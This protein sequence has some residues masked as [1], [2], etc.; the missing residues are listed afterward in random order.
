ME[1]FDPRFHRAYE[2]RQ[3]ADVHKCGRKTGA[4]AGDDEPE[5]SSVRQHVIR[6]VVEQKRVFFSH[7]VFERE[8]QGS[9]DLTIG[10]LLFGSRPEDNLIADTIRG[11]AHGGHGACSVPLKLIEYE[12][13]SQVPAISE[14]VLANLKS[15]DGEQYTLFLPTNEACLDFVKSLGQYNPTVM[16]YRGWYGARHDTGPLF[17]PTVEELESIVDTIFNSKSDELTKT[18]LWDAF[19]SALRGTFMNHI[20]RGTGDPF[21]KDKTSF[22]TLNGERFNHLRDSFSKCVKALE[23]EKED[24]VPDEKDE[25]FGNVQSM[26]GVIGKALGDAEDVKADGGKGNLTC[27]ISDDKEDYFPRTVISHGVDRNYFEPVG[28]NL[29]ENKRAKVIAHYKCKNGTVFL[30]DKVLAP[31]MLPVGMLLPLPM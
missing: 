7:N 22:V 11:R 29:P 30:I 16:F 1:A 10:D 15:S 18:H 28:D 23:S 20:I 14:E 25:L 31:L 12:T 2:A 8:V 4:E 6:N 27:C 3:S 5:L 13:K 24:G 21:V 19:A 9:I 26:F 17:K